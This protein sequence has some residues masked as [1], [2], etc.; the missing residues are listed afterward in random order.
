MFSFLSFFSKYK[1]TTLL[2]I[3]SIS[4][5]YIATL[6]Y[7]YMWQIPN[8][9]TILLY[10]IIFGNTAILITNVYTVL[11][12]K[13]EN[14]Y[15]TFMVIITL[16]A[17]GIIGYQLKMVEINSL[18]AMKTLT[19]NTTEYITAVNGNITIIRR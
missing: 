6:I 1:H 13:K 18:Q 3:L 7:P 14:Y 19:N 4:I 5:I 10:A 8:A 2:S 12:T 16:I 15:M 11:V 17:F 9:Y